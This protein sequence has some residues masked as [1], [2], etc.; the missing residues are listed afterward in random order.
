M[1]ITAQPVQRLRL[2]ATLCLSLAALPGAASAITVAVGSGDDPCPGGYSLLSVGEAQANQTTACNALSPWDIARLAGGGSMD[3]SGYGC[4]IRSSDTRHLASSLCRP[5]PAPS[6]IITW[7][8]SC[9]S[10]QVGATGNVT[11]TKTPNGSGFAVT[12]EGTLTIYSP[13]YGYVRHG[14]PAGFLPVSTSAT[15]YTCSIQ[16]L[17]GYGDTSGIGNYGGQGVHIRNDSTSGYAGKATLWFPEKFYNG[18]YTLR[19]TWVTNEATNPLAWQSCSGITVL[20]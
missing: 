17:A 18:Q 10:S 12:L 7:N 15:A 8:G 11:I 2:T 9:T 14:L 6:S 4:G 19:C 3:G 5:T 20:Q 13:T 1:S 16:Q